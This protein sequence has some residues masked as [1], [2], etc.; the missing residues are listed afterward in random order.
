MSLL[1]E[2]VIGWFQRNLGIGAQLLLAGLVIGFLAF[3]QRTFAQG[4][5]YL[6]VDGDVPTPI[7]LSEAE[8]KSLPRMPM[9]AK[10]EAG[11]DETFEGV[12]LATLLLRAG[13]PLRDMLKGAEVAKYLHVEGSDGFAAAIALPE[14]DHGT[15]LVADTMNGAP[16]P[17][18]NGPLQVISPN[19]TRHSRWVK[20]LVLLRIKTTHK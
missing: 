18:A 17:A 10:D 20:H 19:E 7:S 2:A 6:A 15:F 9:T 1:V 8:F 12:D 14:F 13:A 16:L 3:S 4:T 5:V 11:H